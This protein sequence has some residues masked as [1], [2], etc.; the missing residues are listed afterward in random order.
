MKNLIIGIAGE[1]NSGKDTVASMIAYMLH[2]GLTNASS[3]EF[4]IKRKSYEITN[5][6]KIIHYGDPLKKVCA[7][8][9][10]LP[11]EHFYSREHKDDLWYCIKEHRFLTEAEASMPGYH[12]VTIK[13]LEISSLASIFKVVHSKNIVIKLRTLLQYVGDNLCRN[14]L[15]EDVWIDCTISNAADI[16]EV[17][18]V[19]IVPDIRFANENNA[20]KNHI[21]GY[22][23]LLTRDLQ[24]DDDYH[25]SEDI[26]FETSAILKN[27]G[28][29]VQLFYKLINVVKDIIK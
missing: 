18:K 12:K 5:A 20:I 28:T 14:N 15:D 29:L 9:Y 11:L 13:M 23:I 17:N 2:V 26:D 3:S 21:W 16:A 25:E 10:N 8:I 1:K 24:K 22:T 7:T 6:H 4:L 27:N 19:C